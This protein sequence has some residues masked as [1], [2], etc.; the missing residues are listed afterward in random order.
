M[1]TFDFAVLNNVPSEPELRAIITQYGDGYEQTSDEGINNVVDKITLSCAFSAKQAVEADR[2]K[3]FLKRHGASKIFLWKKPWES[4]AQK[5]RIESY[6]QE[7]KSA[8]GT[9]LHNFTI[10]LKE[11]FRP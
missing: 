8:S 9:Y 7:S 5:W 6:T 4:A 2:L 11:S 3:S 10:K 1:E